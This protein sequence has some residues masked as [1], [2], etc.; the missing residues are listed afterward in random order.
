VIK[1]QTAKKK[2]CIWRLVNM[3]YSLDVQQMT[4]NLML[5][6]FLCHIFCKDDEKL[7]YLW[8]EIKWF[9]FFRI[10]QLQICVWTTLRNNTPAYFRVPIH[11]FGPSSGMIDEKTSLQQRKAKI[12]TQILF[13]VDDDRLCRFSL[14]LRVGTY[15]IHSREANVACKFDPTYWDQ[16]IGPNRL[17]RKQSSLHAVLTSD[18]QPLEVTPKQEA[19][20]AAQ[21]MFARTPGKGRGGGGG[22]RGGG[23]GGEDAPPA[24][25]GDA[26]VAQGRGR[27]GGRGGGRGDG[28]R[29]GRARAAVAVVMGAEAAAMRLSRKRKSRYM[30][31]C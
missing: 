6:A 21:N 1:L 19:A 22:G 4:T 24:A 31:T 15:H 30:R 28:A 20:R 3:I 8:K 10:K 7:S 5:K 16:L 2:F 29:G 17:A 14:G 18:R 25:G 23:G 9:G 27:G 12:S 26:V 13:S 11:F